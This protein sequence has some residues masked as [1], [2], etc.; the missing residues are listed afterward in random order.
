MGS[1]VTVAATQ[2]RGWRSAR[3]RVLL[4]SM[5]AFLIAGVTGSAHLAFNNPSFM[6]DLAASQ[7]P[8][9]QDP[10]PQDPA[11]AQAAVEA[12][13]DQASAE[14][15]NASHDSDSDGMPDQWETF[16]GLN[17][18]SN[19]ASGD[20]DND[21]L[22]NLQEFQKGGHPFGA[23]KRYF[24][25]GS[26]GFFDTS[27]GIVNL[28]ATEDAKVQLTFMGESGVIGTHRVTVPAGKRQTVNAA[29]V[30]G[31]NTVLATVIESD[32]GMVADRL[33]RWG[34]NG[35][36]SQVDAG[37][38]APATTWYLA[39]GSTG[40]FQLYYLL[41]NPGLSPAQVTVKYLRDGA[42]PITKTYTV[43]AQSRYTVFVNL[44]D[45]GLV[46]AAV[47]AEITST[48][49]IVAERAMYFSVNRVF[50]AGT[51][52]MGVPQLATQWQFAESSTGPFFDEFVS[53]LNPSTTQTATATLT[54]HLSGGGTLVRNYTVS[55]ERRR[56]VY[57]NLEALTD[58]GLA[59]LQNATFWMTVDSTIPIAAERVMWWPRGTLW[60]EGHASTGS[61]AANTS[62]VVPEGTAGNG[63]P[64]GSGASDQTYVLIANTSAAAGQV[65]LTLIP[66]SGATSTVTLPIAAFERLSI[67]VAA[68]FS[69]TNSRF[70]VLVD[71]LGTP[72]VPIVVDYARYASPGGQTWGAGGASQA[73][74]PPAQTPAD[75]A[76]TVT[77]TTPANGATNVLLHGNLTAT[78]RSRSASRCR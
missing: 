13:G 34:G 16:F 55:P 70:S 3:T 59:A 60:Y 2:R 42:G 5:L 38:A 28:N 39:E 78:S 58:P 47:G 33:I 31:N 76:P 49:P 51:G 54:F 11:A 37:A 32:K 36:G 64:G 56:T 15:H 45:L 57:L 7:D 20:P 61:P 77:A 74:I 14:S 41:L 43:P 24:A 8:A 53:L 48:Q 29:S 71:S 44:A 69:L 62:W 50:D 10:A 52:A 23:F 65:R 40:L 63:G 19:D 9:T 66:D 46:L 73:I 75:T 22:T 4:V 1:E 68:Q 26:T 21:G 35:Y 72:G 30:L 12:A 27:F 17:P 6:N 67:N 18:A 25:E